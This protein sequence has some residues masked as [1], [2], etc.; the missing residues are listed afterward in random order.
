MNEYRITVLMGS[1]VEYTGYIAS[2]TD[3][4]LG[5][6]DRGVLTGT[7]TI[8]R[9]GVLQII[10]GYYFDQYN[11]AT[12]EREV[13]TF[14]MDFIRTTISTVGVSSWEALKGQTILLLGDA[15]RNVMGIA[16][17]WDPQKVFVFKDLAT[18]WDDR[19]ENSKRTILDMMAKIEELESRNL[20]TYYYV[21]QDI[22]AD[23]WSVYAEDYHE[24]SE[25]PIDGSQSWVSSHPTQDEAI[26]EAQ[27]LRN[28]L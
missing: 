6:E 26:N 2:I 22:D 28:Q 17:I 19:V 24:G 1:G 20:E 27:K 13:L 10:G 21:S 23:T 18:M 5:V 14:G 16:N 15:D 8:Q 3:T 9:G 7:L 11:E 12:G 25:E 4:F